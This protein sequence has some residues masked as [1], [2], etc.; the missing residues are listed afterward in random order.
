MN[1]RG[2]SFWSL[3]LLSMVHE[4]VTRKGMEAVGTVASRL[5]A[6]QPWRKDREENGQNGNSG[7]QVVC[8][9]AVT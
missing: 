5:Y 3:R 4:V 6:F 2:S 9:S 7:V 8:L 1:S